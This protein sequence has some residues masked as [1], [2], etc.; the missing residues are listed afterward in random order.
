VFLSPAVLR[1]LRPPTQVLVHVIEGLT[2]SETM[3]NDGA[4][5]EKYGETIERDGATMD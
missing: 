2:D 1:L 4:S 3:D 5:M